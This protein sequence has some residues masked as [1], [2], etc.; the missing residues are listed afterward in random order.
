MILS[1]SVCLSSVTACALHKRLDVAGCH[2]ACRL[3]LTLTTRMQN[4][5][6]IP[7]GVAE[8]C[9]QISTA[10]QICTIAWSIDGASGMMD[11]RSWF[12]EHGRREA[13][14]GRRPLPSAAPPSQAA[15]APDVRPR[16]ILL[17]TLWSSCRQCA[18]LR[19]LIDA[20]SHCHRSV[21]YLTIW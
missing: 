16:R 21:G 12:S 18:A 13:V 4:L 9:P 19:H 14:D 7:L 20:R 6:A 5:V 2:L 11:G 1:S 8:L 3:I 10:A 15:Q 17:T